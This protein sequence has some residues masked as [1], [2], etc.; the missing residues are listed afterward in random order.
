VG[1]MDRLVWWNEE[2]VAMVAVHLIECTL[3]ARSR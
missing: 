2:M 1:S 3:A